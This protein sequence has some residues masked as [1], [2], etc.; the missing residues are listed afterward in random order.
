MVH[1]PSHQCTCSC[2]HCTG[3]V[4]AIFCTG[5]V[6]AIFFAPCCTGM[7][8]LY[9]WVSVIFLL[10]WCDRCDFLSHRCSCA[11]CTGAVQIFD[12][13][14]LNKRLFI[15][16]IEPFSQWRYKCT[17][18]C[19]HCIQSYFDPMKLISK[20]INYESERGDDLFFWRSLKFWAI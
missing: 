12:L 2:A 3:V 16:L 6:D 7:I 15:W 5:A 17:A 19:F 1:L 18:Q 11:N 4:S 20:S 13:S 9:R 10:H 14:L 8:F